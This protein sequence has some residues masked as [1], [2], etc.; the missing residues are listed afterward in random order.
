MMQPLSPAHKPLWVT[1]GWGE[2]E[3][4]ARVVGGGKGGGWGWDG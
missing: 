1:R 4:L 2:K 3:K